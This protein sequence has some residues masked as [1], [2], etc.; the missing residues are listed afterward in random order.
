MLQLILFS[1]VLFLVFRVLDV[2]D[3]LPEIAK[4][5]PDVLYEPLR[6]FQRGEVPPRWHVG[7]AAE[8]ENPFRPLAGRAQN[9]PGKR[10]HGG[11]DGYFFAATQPPGGVVQPVV[12]VERAVDRVCQPVDHDVG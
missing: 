3:G 6:L 4:K 11:W 1:L 2:R 10:C 5:G 9:F 12:E 7:P 8:V